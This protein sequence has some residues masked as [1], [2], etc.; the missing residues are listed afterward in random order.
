MAYLCCRLDDKA[1][2]DAFNGAG[3]QLGRPAANAGSGKQEALPPLGPSAPPP[4]GAS[5]QATTLNA[6]MS[7]AEPAA[8][9]AGNE[10]GMTASFAAVARL[11]GSS[12]QSILQQAAAR[13]RNNGGAKQVATRR[14]SWGATAAPSNGADPSQAAAEPTPPPAVGEP[15]TTKADNKQETEDATDPKNQ[16]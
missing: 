11:P 8:A 7:A 6:I 3:L 2:R 13:G 1:L 10:P 9:A 4:A 16:A 14:V 15:T 5:P 12:L